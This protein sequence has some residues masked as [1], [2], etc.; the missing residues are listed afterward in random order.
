[1]RTTGA[2]G[3]WL[4]T[5]EAVGPNAMTMAAI[6][7]EQ[8]GLSQEHTRQVLSMDSDW[9]SVCERFLLDADAE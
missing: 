9:R 7:N 3:H 5:S 6:P 4:Q 8:M 2:R 1:M